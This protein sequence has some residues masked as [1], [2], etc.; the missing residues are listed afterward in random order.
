MPPNSHPAE[1]YSEITPRALL[2]RLFDAAL[3]GARSAAGVEAHLKS[4][5]P[6]GSG[7]VIVVGAGK[8]AAEMAQVVERNVSGEVSG[9]VIVPD[10]Y[11]ATCTHIEVAEASHPLPDDRGLRA[12]AR[13]MNLVQAAKAGDIVICLL[14]GGASSLLIAPAESVSLV[15]KRAIVTALL[16]SGSSIDEINCVRKHL[17]AVKGGRLAN[18][19]A[20]A[21][22]LSL[23][24]SDVVGDDLAVIASGPTVP[25]P[26][27][28]GDALAVLRRHGIALSKTIENVLTSHKT[29]TPKTLSANVSTHIVARPTDAL[30]AS[31]ALA[32]RLGLSVHNL[33]D[34]CTGSALQGAADHA[35]LVRAILGGQGP[36]APPCVIL[37]GGEYTVEVRGPGR[38]GPN[39]EFVLALALELEGIG[40][41]WALSA[42]TDGVDG[43]AGAAG[44]F[45]TPDTLARARAARHDVRQALAANDSA[46]IFSALQDLVAPGPTLTNV[47]D[48]RAIL[49]EPR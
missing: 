11:A 15:E 33:G 16:K 5:S 3:A 36:V 12:T 17:S 2:R 9:L 38:G 42:D 46:S 1:K 49:V 19:A 20:P 40:G 6:I 23:V 41:V 29:E 47:N 34:T 13:V 32:T 25:D 39:T 27:T 37:S 14:S 18:L 45:L 7:R 48:F 26:T 31:A 35:A 21:T 28:C 10:G 30:A 43:V 4:L 24:V 44:A 8:A 22:I